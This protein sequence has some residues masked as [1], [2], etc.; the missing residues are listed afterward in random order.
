[1]HNSL[2]LTVGISIYPSHSQDAETLIQHA[3]NA[4]YKEKSEGRNSYQFFT[5]KIHEQVLNHHRMANDL[6]IALEYK[7]FQVYYQPVIHLKTQ[8]I[9][10]AEALIHW[11]HPAEGLF[12]QNN[13][14]PSL[15]N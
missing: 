5:A 1:M 10:G 8:Q 2:F 13:L 6:K 4:M 14:F 9:V 3:D 15:K 11:H 12:H 7:N